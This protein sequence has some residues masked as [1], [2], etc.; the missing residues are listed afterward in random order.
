MYVIE[1]IISFIYIYTHT[2]IYVAVSIDAL[3]F[4]ALGMIGVVVTVSGTY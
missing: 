2:H 3:Q 1:Y 4:A